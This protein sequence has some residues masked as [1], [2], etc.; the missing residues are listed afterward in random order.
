MMKLWLVIYVLG[1]AVNINGPIADIDQCEA[2]R[3]SLMSDLADSFKP[4]GKAEGAKPFRG[5]NLARSDF[6]LTCV[7]AEGR[8]RMGA[9][10]I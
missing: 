7:K 10:P 8:P 5:V 3:A 2:R 1:K 9:A 4:G 6:E